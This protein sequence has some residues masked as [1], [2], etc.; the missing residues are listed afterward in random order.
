MPTLWRLGD[1]GLLAAVLALAAVQVASA[2]EDDG[3]QSSGPN[4]SLVGEELLVQDVTLTI[5]CDPSRVST[6]QYSASG[7]AV[8][9]YPGTFTVQGTVTIAPQTLP[10]PRTGTVAGP[11]ESLAETFTINSLVGTVTGTKTLPPGGATSSD[12]GSCQHVTGFATGP[13]SNA[14][15][16]VVDVFSQPVYSATVQQPSGTSG[17][18][19]DASLSFSELELDGVCASGSCHYRLAGFDQAFLT[20]A[21]LSDFCDDDTNLDND[22]QEPCEDPGHQ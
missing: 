2:D 5:D 7:T 10:G 9:P 8:G 1:I 17:A 18:Q 12:E 16:T 11:L 15:G 4:P 3:G 21:P 20:S 13:V 22:S 6:V 14:S 19:G